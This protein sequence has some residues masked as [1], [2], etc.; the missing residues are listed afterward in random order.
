MKQYMPEGGDPSYL[1]N[2]GIAG[3]WG[4]SSLGVTKQ[5]TA[6]TVNISGHVTCALQPA[7]H[8]LITDLRRRPLIR[9]LQYYALKSAL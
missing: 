9:I 3:C 8:T 7:V 5:M 2:L 4:C 6:L 1:G